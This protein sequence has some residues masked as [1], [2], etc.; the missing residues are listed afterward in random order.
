MFRKSRRQ[1]WLF[2]ISAFFLHAI[3]VEELIL[4]QNLEEIRHMG[5][6][7]RFQADSWQRKTLWILTVLF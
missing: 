2:S 1:N 6:L 5:G 4:V 3:V 7:K